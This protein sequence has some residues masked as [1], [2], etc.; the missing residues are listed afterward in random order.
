VGIN[1]A[2]T[3]GTD[4]IYDHYRTM[5]AEGFSSFPWSRDRIEVDYAPRRTLIAQIESCD[6]CGSCQANCPYGLPVVSML[7][8][9]VPAMKDIIRTWDVVVDRANT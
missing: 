2:G 1:I 8:S 7:K 6:E 3:L 9:M 4:V 5:G